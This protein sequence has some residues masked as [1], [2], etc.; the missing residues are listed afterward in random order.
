MPNIAACEFLALS[1]VGL[2]HRGW[3]VATEFIIVAKLPLTFRVDHSTAQLEDASR[4]DRL[5]IDHVHSRRSPT[6]AMMRHASRAVMHERLGPAYG[7]QST[8][9]I[10]I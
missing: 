7:P 3:K 2:T 1:N 10:R 4:I 5:S 9:S 8:K 6:V